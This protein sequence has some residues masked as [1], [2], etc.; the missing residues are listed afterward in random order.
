MKQSNCLKA[1]HE[2]MLIEVGQFKVQLVF[3][4]NYNQ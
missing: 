2:I 4:N 3:G 1:Y